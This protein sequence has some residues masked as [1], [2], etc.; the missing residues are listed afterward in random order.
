MSTGSWWGIAVQYPCRE[1]TIEG[2]RILD[3]GAGELFTGIQLLGARDCVIQGNEFRVMGDNH[4]HGA[5][6][7]ALSSFDN[8]EPHRVHDVVIRQNAFRG[9]TGAA[10]NDGAIQVIGPIDGGC[11]REGNH[12][13]VDLDIREMLGAS[14]ECEG[15]NWSLDDW[16]EEP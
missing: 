6:G 10:P 16:D 12:F 3:E 1:W 15:K 8:G 2:N 11:E 14:N 9:T 4:L 5:R 7:I 13:A